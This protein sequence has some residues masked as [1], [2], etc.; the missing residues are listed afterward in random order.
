MRAPCSP[1]PAFPAPCAPRRRPAAAR[2]ADRVNYNQPLGSMNAMAALVSYLP[3]SDPRLYQIAE[4]NGQLPAKLLEAAAAGGR[5][6]LLT[7]AGVREV[8]RLGDGRYLLN[9]SGTAGGQLVFFLVFGDR[10]GCRLAALVTGWV[11]R[12]LLRAHL[13]GLALTARANSLPLPLPQSPRARLTLSSSPR[14]WRAATSASRASRR[15]PAAW[16]KSACIRA[17]PPPP[18]AAHLQALGLHPNQGD[19]GRLCSVALA[20]ALAALLA[21][22]GR[23]SGLL[24]L[25]RLLGL[26]GGA[27]ERD[28]SQ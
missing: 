26:W 9:V 2:P 25:F 6:R 24:A 8:A 12:W 17:P 13:P 23:G 28:G 27:C 19:L 20:L 5:A 14:R 18:P 7:G 21:G 10:A 16:P 22:G 4:G 1:V 11:R 15:R 3:A